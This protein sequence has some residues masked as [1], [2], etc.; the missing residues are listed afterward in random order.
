MTL[1]SQVF[2]NLS[3]LTK[4]THTFMYVSLNEI[5]SSDN[6]NNILYF[7]GNNSNLVLTSH[8]HILVTKCVNY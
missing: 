6:I 3:D 4:S 5:N 8:F 1:Q 7:L 2:F